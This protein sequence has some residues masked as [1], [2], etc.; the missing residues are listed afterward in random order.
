MALNVICMRYNGVL[1]FANGVKHM[2]DYK[3]LYLSLAGTLAN[4]IEEL[5]LLT[6]RLKQEQLRMEAE[7]MD[8]DE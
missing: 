2:T 7:V 6:E 5:E 1:Y 8:G 3:E 4:T